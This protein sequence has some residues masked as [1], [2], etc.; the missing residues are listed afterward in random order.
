[1]IPS[2]IVENIAKDFVHF[3]TQCFLY[4]GQGFLVSLLGKIIIILGDWLIFSFRKT[5]SVPLFVLSV[6]NLSF[7]FPAY[8]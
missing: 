5:Y 1:M 3:T 8:L 2:L 4:E 7:T 6:R